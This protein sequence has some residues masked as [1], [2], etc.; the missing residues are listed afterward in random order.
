MSRICSSVEKPHLQLFCFVVLAMKRTFQDN[1]TRPWWTSIQH[2]L[3]LARLLG[4]L[5]I[6][7]SFGEWV[8]CI[9]HIGKNI[10]IISVVTLAYPTHPISTIPTPSNFAFAVCSHQ[11]H[12]IFPLPLYT[13]STSYLIKVKSSV[14]HVNVIWDLPGADPV[15]K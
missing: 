3:V 9:S 5:D 12:P 4:P 1:P 2:Q 10:F 8:Q 7:Y 15:A 13:L 14:V 6:N 11:G